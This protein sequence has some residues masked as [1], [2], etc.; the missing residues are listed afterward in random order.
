MKYLKK[1]AS[2]IELE[3]LKKTNISRKLK[4]KINKQIEITKESNRKFVDNL[5]KSKW[6]KLAR[7]QTIRKGDA[8]RILI[9]KRIVYNLDP[10]CLVL[11]LLDIGLKATPLFFEYIDKKEG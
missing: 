10:Y 2:V 1:R 9:G 8:T 5:L 11:N 7:I 6:F 4:E 3:K